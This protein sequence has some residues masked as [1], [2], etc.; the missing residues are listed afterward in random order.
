M[1]FTLNYEDGAR[2]AW[3][4]QNGVV[5][6]RKDHEDGITILVKLSQAAKERFM[7]L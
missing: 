1:T 3:L 5:L 4:Y 2:L 7:R 6:D